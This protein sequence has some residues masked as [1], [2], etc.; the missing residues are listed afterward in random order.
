MD[1]GPWRVAPFWPG[2]SGMITAWPPNWARAIGQSERQRNRSR[3]QTLE[4]SVQSGEAANRTNWAE[5]PIGAIGQSPM[6]S[7]IYIYIY[8]EAYLRVE[9]S[10]Q[11]RKAVTDPG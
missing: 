4:Q 8:Q 6:H 7:Y 5:A 3:P 11:Q 10:E 1:P 2:H 9:R